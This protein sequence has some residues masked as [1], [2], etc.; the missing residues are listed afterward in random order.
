MEAGP[1]GSRVFT[2]GSSVCSVH[3]SALPHP[4]HTAV[5]LGYWDTSHFL[6]WA[7]HSRCPVSMT[8]PCPLR[9]M[10]HLSQEWLRQDGTNQKLVNHKEKGSGGPANSASP[11]LAG[12]L[13]KFPNVSEPM[14]LGYI[15]GVF[16]A[17]IS[18]STQR[19]ELV[20]GG[21][22]FLPPPTCHPSAPAAHPLP[23]SL[24]VVL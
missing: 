4:H 15:E 7:G 16:S 8:I 5:G 17:R 14:C 12:D 3:G 21:L 22:F 20:R 24:L 10:T 9:T 6:S 1:L 18:R 11:P 2:R 13:C 19:A 23:S